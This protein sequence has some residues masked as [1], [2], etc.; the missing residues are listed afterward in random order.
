MSMLNYQ[1]VPLLK[2]MKVSWDDKIPNSNWVQIQMR[3]L[4]TK[5][6]LGLRLHEDF[7]ANGR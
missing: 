2:N 5:R 3:A 6:H 4:F 1:R 7:V